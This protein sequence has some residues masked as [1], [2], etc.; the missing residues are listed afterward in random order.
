MK[1]IVPQINCCIFCNRLKFT[2]VEL[3]VVIGILSILFA[4]LSPALQVAK[5]QGRSISC[6]NN[7]R[8]MSQAA[9]A[10]TVTYDDYFP[11]AYTS[12]AAWDVKV[13]GIAPNQT[14]EPGLL[15]ESVNISSNSNAVHQCPSFNGADM[16]GGESYTGYNYNTTYIGCYNP[17]DNTKPAK[18]SIIKKPSE[19]VIFGDAAYEG[20]L[21]ANK[22]MRS[23]LDDFA[24]RAAGTQHFRHLGATNTSF[25]DGHATN[26]YKSFRNSNANVYGLCGWIS[27]DDSL[28]DLK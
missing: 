23:P 12:S 11:I 9:I 19:T 7:I 16:W 1:N 26:L 2:L 5:E 10:Y 21:N 15:W 22:F 27:E 13:L 3:L 20:G 8:Q 17:N 24:L 6:I 28:Y 4:M 14:F 18:V 25:V